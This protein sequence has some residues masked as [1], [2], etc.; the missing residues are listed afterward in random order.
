[1]AQATFISLLKMQ[2][3]LAAIILFMVIK[4][5]V[6]WIFFLLKG[7]SIDI[8]LS[9]KMPMKCFNLNVSDRVRDKQKEKKEGLQAILCTLFP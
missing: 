5:T 4:G 8:I 1:M 7:V 6:A 3:V 2:F 9:M